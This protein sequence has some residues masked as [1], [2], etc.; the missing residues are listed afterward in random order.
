APTIPTSAP[1]RPNATMRPRA[2]EAGFDRREREPE[3]FFD[4]GPRLPLGGSPPLPDLGA[5]EGGAPV[6]DLGSFCTRPAVS[7][8][9]PLGIGRAA[10]CGGGARRTA[11]NA[12]REREMNGRSAFATSIT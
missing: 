10:P 6:P 11:S 4:D 9:I 8:T 3:P 5:L 12:N 7:G 2:C 1:A